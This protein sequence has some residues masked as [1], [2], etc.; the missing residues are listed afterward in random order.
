MSLDERVQTGIAITAA[1][2]GVGHPKLST[3]NRTLN[4]L[5]SFLYRISGGRVP[6]RL[7]KAPI[8]L[9]TTTGSKSGKRR[10]NPVLYMVDGVNLVTVAS[11]GGADKNPSWFVNLM[12]NPEAV[13]TIK[14][15]KRKVRARRAT[16]DERIQ[17]WPLLTTM[18]QGYDDY[19]KKTKREIPVVIL[20]LT[21]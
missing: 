10:T 21:N 11:A 4:P 15:E 6:A 13:V 19:S 12:H 2:G 14:R 9:L 18:F 17:L 20:A 1:R 3:A 7:G 8:M 5:V 16:P